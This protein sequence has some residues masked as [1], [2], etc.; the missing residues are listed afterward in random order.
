[1]DA[2]TS[3]HWHG[4][5]A[6]ST[7]LFHHSKRFYCGKQQTTNSTVLQVES[8]VLWLGFFL[9]REEQTKIRIPGWGEGLSSF[10]P[11]C[12]RYVS[13]THTS[14][15]FHIFIIKWSSVNNGFYPYNVQWAIEFIGFSDWVNNWLTLAFSFLSLFCASSLFAVRI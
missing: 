1:M 6:L 7:S 5:V 2:L 13:Y 14:T 11:F 8:S 12:L 15:V 9:T 3:F 4:W 10:D